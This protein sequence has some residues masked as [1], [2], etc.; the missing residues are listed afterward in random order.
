L[1]Q[2][3]R[4]ESC[5]HFKAGNLDGS[6]PK[7]ITMLTDPNY[8]LPDS[9]GFKGTH[10]DDWLALGYY[11]MQ[12]L[13]FT[14]HHTQLDVGTYNVPVFWLRTLLNKMQE[15]K[16]ATAIRKKCA[17]LSVVYKPA[18]ITA[19]IEE[20]YQVYR[21]HVEFSTAITCASYLHQNEVE[22]PFDSWMV[23]LRDAGKLV[24]VGYF[25]RGQNTMAG[26]LNFYHPA[27]QKYSPGKYLILKKIDYANGNNIPF[28]YTGYISTVN[29]KFD[30][31][32]FPCPN[33]VEVYL[34]IENLWVPFKMIGKENLQ[35]YFLDYLI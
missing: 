28:Y 7:P 15:Q 25:D 8:I 10:F 35:Q 14:T 5:E 22:N 18:A 24:A 32:L 33:A 3:C 19:E 26:I 16:S 27:Y 12:H 31:K 4:E 1:N 30:Y 9:A 17:Q 6:T 23:E 20:L 2:G 13:I 34:P 21:N 11:R 29:T